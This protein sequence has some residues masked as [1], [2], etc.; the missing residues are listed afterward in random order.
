MA[1]EQE[2]PCH[3][4]ASTIHLLGMHQTKKTFVS[5]LFLCSLELMFIYK[6]M[7]LS[8]KTDVH[9]L[10][11]SVRSMNIRWILMYI[12]QAEEHKSLCSSTTSD[13]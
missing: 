4:G 5:R 2:P 8:F 3:T 6:N 9:N 12:S 10:C 7:F 13:P 11:T 1:N